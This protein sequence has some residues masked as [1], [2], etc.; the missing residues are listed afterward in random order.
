MPRKQNPSAQGSRVL[1]NS[2]VGAS[3]ESLT[4]S[5]FRAQ[6]L[7]GAYGIRPELAAM[8]AALAFGGHG[9]G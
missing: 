2:L 7:I 3:T 8:V 6:H 1:W 5:A 9:Y 4:L